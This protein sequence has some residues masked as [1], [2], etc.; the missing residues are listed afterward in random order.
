MSH[1]CR[2][3]LSKR[4]PNFLQNHAQ[5]P[6]TLKMQDSA[7]LL[8]LWKNLSK[9]ERLQLRKWLQ[10]PFHNL[11][12][13]TLALFELLVAT[14]DSALDAL[15][16]PAVFAQLFPGAAYDNDLLN[17]IFSFLK[18]QIEGFL[19]WEEI[20]RNEPDWH[21][22]HLARALRKRGIPAAFERKIA[23][24]EKTHAEKPQRNSAWHLLCYQIQHERLAHQSLQGRDT[25]ADLSA[26]SDALA[27]FFLLE[28]IRLNVTALS[29]KSLYG[30]DFRLPLSTEALAEAERQIAENQEAGRRNAA[31]SVSALE[32]MRLSFRAQH[33]PEDAANFEQLKRLLPAS[34]Q[35]FGAAECHDLYRTAI[36]FA[37]RRH[38]RGERP[39]YTREAFDLYRAAL[40]NGFLFESGKLPKA[41]YNNLNRLACLLGE[42][43][44]ARHFLEKYRDALPAAERENTYRFNL[45]IFHYLSGD[46]AQ[47]PALLQAFEFTDVYMNLHAREML[48]KSYF[49]LREWIALDSL[50]DSFYTYLRRRKDL[51]YHRTTFLNFIKY[52][53]KVMRPSAGQ[54]KKAAQLAEKIRAE[55]YVAGREWLLEKLG[56]GQDGPKNVPH[57]AG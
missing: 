5:N 47:V 23:V 53:R 2:V 19:A 22:L 41:A 43:E 20:T 34:A 50:C 38:N 33:D 40:E 39:G 13:D 9:T 57:P 8:Q 48:L 37:L 16:K 4:L 31:P 42:R 54:R 29:M 45:A 11:R 17:H 44:F 24:L 25:A 32:I 30:N 26:V 27:Q 56:V 36:N 46:F 35:L 18:K 3:G 12:A 55:E 10:S 15:S 21:Q 52:I 7:A 49:E 14:P 6:A 51:G 28:N 1:F